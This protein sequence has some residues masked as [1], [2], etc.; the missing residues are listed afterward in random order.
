MS[1]Y[2]KGRFWHY[3]FQYQGRRFYGSTGQETKRAAETVERAKRLEAAT[4]SHDDAS[5]M[6]VEAAANRYW[7][8]IGSDLRGARNVE[9]QLRVMMTCVGPQKLLKEISTPDVV[10]AISRRRG[11]DLGRGAPSKTTVNRDIIDSTLRPIMNRARKVWGARGLSDIDWAAVRFTEPEPEHR[12][13]TPTQIEAWKSELDPIPRF[14][15]HL[16]LRYGLRLSELNF[17]PRDVDGEGGRLTIRGKSRKSGAVLIL[18]L[19]EEDARILAGLAG[20]AIAMGLPTVWFYGD[21][22]QSYK[23]DALGRVLRRTGKSAGLDMGRLVHGARHHAGTQI[24]RRTGN[25]KLAQRL[26]GH[27]SIQSTVR[28]AHATEADLRDALDDLSRNGPEASDGDLDNPLKRK[29]N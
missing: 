22:P 17:D 16:L 7:I 23:G 5:K 18:P 8:E 13:Y 25:L 11:M 12:E 27:A 19:L 4:G 14:A 9:R 10:D 28:Y 29:E 15:L 26:L 24:L 20:R 3:D 2:R 1:V 21:P 6:T